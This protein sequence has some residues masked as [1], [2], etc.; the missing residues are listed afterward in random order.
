MIAIIIDHPARDLPP[1][2]LLAE[3]LIKNKLT[4]KVIFVPLYYAKAN[5]VLL[6]KYYNYLVLNYARSQNRELIYHLKKKI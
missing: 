2:I 4:N 1:N 3:E 6:E 5:L